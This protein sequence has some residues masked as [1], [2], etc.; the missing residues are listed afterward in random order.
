MVESGK[1]KLN[2]PVHL[3]IDPVL[4]RSWHTTLFDL[5]DRQPNIKRVT[6]EMLL[7]HT[8]GIQDYPGTLQLQVE[9]GVEFGPKELIDMT[10]KQLMCANLPCRKLYSSIGYVLLGL[11]MTQLTGAATWADWDQFA[12]IPAA[13]RHLYNATTFP[14]LGKCTLY[15][16]IAH[17]YAQ[18][19]LPSA[20]IPGKTYY[21]FYDVSD[22][23]CLNGWAMG[24]IAA[25]G[26]N[27]AMFFRDL[28]AP[29]P[30]QELISASLAAQ[31]TAPG[32]VGPLTNNGFCGLVGVPEYNCDRAPPKC[33][34]L[35]AP[36]HGGSDCCQCSKPP[37]GTAPSA[38]GWP[39]CS[40]AC[41]TTFTDSTLTKPQNVECYGV[42][43]CPGICSAAVD[44]ARCPYKYGLGMFLMDQFR[45][46]VVPGSGDPNDALYWGHGGIDYGSGSA[47][48]C[49]YNYKYRFGFCVNYNSYTGQLT[50]HPWLAHLCSVDSSG[51]H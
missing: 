46:F 47:G 25:S 35:L 3:A 48:I 18:E 24:N 40:R 29:P 10:D 27:L 37:P 19:V 33:A 49:G 28:Y 31:M 50:P 34:A 2:T 14:K 44:E 32:N 43:A 13:R 38:N 39:G 17:Q 51:S 7:G 26:L 42:I 45:E 41:L 21:N 23:S 4:Q 15:G 6:Y 1:I 5:F 9:A 11:A 8:G 12:V 30:G 22:D 36:L 20:E 16:N